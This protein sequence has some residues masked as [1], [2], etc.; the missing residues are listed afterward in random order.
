MGAEAKGRSA[1]CGEMARQLNMELQSGEPISD[2]LGLYDS[3]VESAEQQ[4]Q[5]SSY[6]RA[7]EVVRVQKLIDR[8]ARSGDEDLEIEEA[9]GA[10]SRTLRC[11]VLNQD[12]EKPVKSTVCGHVY[13]LA[14]VISALYQEQRVMDERRFPKTLDLVPA[15]YETRCPVVGCQHKISAGK[16][17]RDFGTELTQRQLQSARASVDDSDAVDVL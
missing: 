13:S 14:G 16:L 10:A 15:E 12:I 6:T 5:R 3:G 8:L 7:P 17:K 1:A 4:G 9:V 2:L 11:P